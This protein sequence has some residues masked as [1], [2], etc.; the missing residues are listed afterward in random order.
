MLVDLHTHTT[1]S[2]GALT[3]EQLVQAAAV[4]GVEMLSITDHD[5]V[6][7]YGQL[8]AV[9]GLCLVPGIEFSAHWA[10]RCIHV[11]GLNVDVDALAEAVRGQIA[12]R[13]RRAERIVE[14][15]A[16]RGFGIDIAQ[17]RERAAGAAIGRPHI[18][19]ELVAA[20]AVKDQKTA[21]RKHLG[22]GKAGD[23]KTEWPELAT[24]VE[25]LRA[26]G[27]SA[28]LA[29]PLRYGLT[30]R[31]LALLAADFQAAGGQAVEL[32]S[33]H[34]LEPELTT[35]A[36]LAADLGFSVSLGS[37]FHAPQPWRPLGV[38]SARTRGL[39]A[40]WDAW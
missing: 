39:R 36:D 17:V 27:G 29:H 31:R 23:V 38:D 32:V 15:L 20:G 7:A 6:A 12:A 33:G 3:P 4:A 14:R 19:A 28:V 37:D 2:D 30:R 8:C 10:G 34:V 40:V 9:D 16:K 13:E 18:A 5:S 21:F 26:A 24:V 25:W 1:A 11:V 35:I 22:A